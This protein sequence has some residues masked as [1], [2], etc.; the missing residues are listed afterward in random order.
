M[1]YL[2]HF[3]MNISIVTYT[4]IYIYIS[5]V[6]E[7]DVYGDV[8]VGQH[9]TS[10]NPTLSVLI[11]SVVHDIYIFIFIYT[12]TPNLSTIHH[13]MLYLCTFQ[14]NKTLIKKR[15]EDLGR[16]WEVIK[17]DFSIS[18]KFLD[19]TY[20]IHLIG[21][22]H[23]FKTWRC[24]RVR[25]SSPFQDPFQRNSNQRYAAKLHWVVF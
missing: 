8:H 12:N 13:E 16:I 2:F 1:C 20:T 18:Q 15:H 24:F 5:H 10:Q 3:K 9:Y 4:Y 22:E 6:L 11:C 14:W 7:A 25:N 23:S 19:N 21:L 17:R